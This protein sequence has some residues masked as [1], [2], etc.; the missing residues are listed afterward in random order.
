MENAG[1]DMTH[2][3][4]TRIDESTYFRLKR[5]S[6]LSGR[7]MAHF[8]K[9]ALSL[10]LNKQESASTCV[11]CGSSSLIV[12]TSTNKKFCCDCSNEQEFKLKP[13]QAPLHGPARL[14]K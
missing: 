14:M 8:V 12:M 7:P 13:G 10:Y 11:K 5:L 3:L 1:D 6:E 4:N 9:K 2:Q